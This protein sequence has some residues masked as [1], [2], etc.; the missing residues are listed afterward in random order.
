MFKIENH[1]GRLVEQT[2]AA[3]VTSADLQRCVNRLMAL[4]TELPGK[5]ILV[6]DC[7][8]VLTLAPDVADGFAKVMRADNRR[9]ERSALLLGDSA[10]LNLQ[11]ERMVRESSNPMRRTFRTTDAL[12]T[13]L[14]EVLTADERARLAVLL[15]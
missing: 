2:L 7:R 3:P 15:G 12:I 14:A 6:S 13:W 9:L 11:V 1:V 5:F 4:A 10:T 8:N